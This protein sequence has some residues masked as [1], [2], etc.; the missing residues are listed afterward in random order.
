LYAPVKNDSNILAKWGDEFILINREKI[1]HWPGEG[2][3]QKE[4]VALSTILCLGGQISLWP[5]AKSKI[6]P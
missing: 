5:G 6:S 4:T 1:I 3:F 2:L